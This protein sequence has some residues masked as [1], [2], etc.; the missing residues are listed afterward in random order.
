MEV[1]IGLCC[2][3]SLWVLFAY[4]FRGSFLRID[5]P[6]TELAFAHGYRPGVHPNFFEDGAG[7][8]ASANCA[9]P[10]VTAKKVP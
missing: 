4:R 1:L 8:R 5:P 7:N 3:A 2:V 6:L 10:Q 9:L